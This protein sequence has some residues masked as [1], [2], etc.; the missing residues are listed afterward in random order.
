VSGARIAAAVLGL[1][2]LGVGRA[3]AQPAPV[4]TGT[5]T[6]DVRF[7]DLTQATD[8]VFVSEGYTT[9][10][11]AQFLADAHAAA[12]AVDTDPDA[13]PLRAVK[14]INYHYVFIASPEA[15]PS[16]PG[17]QPGN[18]VFKAHVGPDN[19][20]TADDASVEAAATALA[21]D[22]DTVVLLVKFQGSP[23]GI[24]ANADIKGFG[25]R[26]RLPST[27]AGALVHE[28]G[29]ALFALGDEYP[30]RPGPLSDDDK[31]WVARFP[32]LSLD[33]TGAKWQSIVASVFEG[34]GAWNT[35]VYHPTE[36]CRMN[37]SWSQAFCPVCLSVINGIP[38]AAPGAPVPADPTAHGSV[39]SAT[40][41]TFTWSP[42]SGPRATC[43]DL[44][45]QLLDA[46]A[47]AYHQVLDRT[48]EGQNTS[49]DLGTLAPGKYVVMASSTNLAGSSSYALQYFTVGPGPIA[50]PVVASPVAPTPSSS[51]PADAPVSLGFL[52]ALGR[53]VR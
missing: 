48:V 12:A 46:S 22:V 1:F 6:S 37:E 27:S 4:W 29:H 42:G 36:H 15:A 10:D 35:G 3:E 51:T 2:L 5:V 41:V 45:L 49:A 38:T 17:P 31:G 19:L 44:S 25:S 47:N 24:R 32:N 11:Q 34:G 39:T 33:S 43:Y 50:S 52:G 28:L 21:P 20:L 26:V 9:A 16:T 7:P 13:A 14:K 8:I 53:P 18:T 23:D 30:E 40:P